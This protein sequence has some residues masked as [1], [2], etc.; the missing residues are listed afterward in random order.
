MPWEKERHEW[1]EEPIE[2]K[3]RCSE[4]YRE[5]GMAFLK[6]WVRQHFKGGE[7]RLGIGY[8]CDPKT[9]ER[10]SAVISVMFE[11]AEGIDFTPHELGRMIVFL[12]GIKGK[13][14]FNNPNDTEDLEGLIEILQDGINE[15]RQ[16][17]PKNLN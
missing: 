13:G 10:I 4:P 2:G 16:F 3:E 7:L 6:A 11:D 15:A 17:E 1:L 9:N 14:P 12:K 8:A 5:R